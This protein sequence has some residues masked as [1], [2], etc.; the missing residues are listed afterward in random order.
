MI[1]NDGPHQ[2]LTFDFPSRKFGNTLVLSRS[3]QPKWFTKW[4]WLHYLEEKDAVLCFRCASA[5]AHKLLKDSVISDIS[6]VSKGFCNWKDATRRFNFHESSKCHNEAIYKL[7]ELPSTT[8]NV[9][10]ALS[11]QYIQDKLQRRQNLLKV[12]STIKFLARQGLPLGGMALRQN[13]I[14][15]NC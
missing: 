9:A 3:F 7:I 15:I 11:A 4:P 2:P 12:L 13:Q 6:F 14:F 8:G 10:E 1:L 5:N